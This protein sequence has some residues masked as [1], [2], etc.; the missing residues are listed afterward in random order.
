[1]A[2]VA[3]KLLVKQSWRLL[4]FLIMIPQG[5]SFLLLIIVLPETVFPRLVAEIG[6]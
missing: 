6:E 2:A 3:V 1:M 5:I 4:Y